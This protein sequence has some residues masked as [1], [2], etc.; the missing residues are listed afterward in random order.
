[1][2]PRKSSDDASE[3]K[4]N[5]QGIWKTMLKELSRSK[6]FRHVEDLDKM[7]QIPNERDWFTR[8]I[9]Q[10]LFQKILCL[11]IPLTM[12]C[13]IS[14]K[15]PTIFFTVFFFW[16]FLSECYHHY[17]KILANLFWI[18][19]WILSGISI[20]VF[21][22]FSMG[23]CMISFQGSSREFYRSFFQDISQMLTKI[24]LKVY[25]EWFSTI[26]SDIP[27]RI[28]PR[29]F[30]DISPKYFHGDSSKTSTGVIPETYTRVPPVVFT[31]LLPEVFPVLHPELLTVLLT[32]FCKYYSRIL[33]VLKK[34]FV[35]IRLEFFPAYFSKVRAG[36]LVK[37]HLR[38]HS[39]FFP[40]LL[41][42]DFFRRLS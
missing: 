41:L 25:L 15:T 38:F 22:R 5:P 28:S 7:L 39:E 24:S 4:A 8:K 17:A 42:A 16:E 1:M 40:W 19:P 9:C 27:P 31:G 11:K 33:Q 35:C 26:P 2:A 34:M 29:V 3:T 23:S 36:F 10:G 21:W 18:S 14:H 6:Y 30:L 13:R 12:A 20:D 37:I 32:K